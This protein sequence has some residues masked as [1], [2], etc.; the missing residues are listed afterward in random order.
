MT[1]RVALDTNVVLSALL[2]RG[3]LTWLRDAWSSGVI[4][5]LANSATTGELLRVLGY[6]KFALTAE[7]IEDLLA[8]Y[9]PFVDLVATGPAPRRWPGLTDPDDIKFLVLAKAGGATYLVTGDRA[10]L[11]AEPPP[12]CR[13]LTPSAF[14]V[15]FND[16]LD[17]NGMGG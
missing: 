8:E 15:L 3:S 2:F 5:P 4:L 16:G 10:L 1:V 11:A 12:G 17:K 13:I 14:K 6:P 9:L 7:D